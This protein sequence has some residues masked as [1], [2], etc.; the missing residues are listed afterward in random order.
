VSDLLA[1]E[2]EARA[3]GAGVWGVWT[4][5]VPATDN[6]ERLGR[7]TLATSSSKVQ[8]G[9]ATDRIYLNFD[10]DWRKDFTVLIDRKDNDA[11]RWRVS[12]P[13]R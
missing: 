1:R 8:V 11:S 10:K 4:Y 5:R 2:A 3:K 7:L 13:K 9:E 12:I 6:V